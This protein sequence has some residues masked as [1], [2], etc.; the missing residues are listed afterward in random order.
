MALL[1][2][3]NIFGV[4]VTCVTVDNPRARQLNDYPGLNG[5][6]SLDQGLRGRFSDVQGIL[7]GEDLG[8][9]AALEGTVRSYYDGQVH[10]LTDSAGVD[11]SNVLLES[12]EPQ[13]KIRI[14][15]NDGACFRPYRCRFLH[16][17]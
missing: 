11:W 10:T 13:G 9:L 5:R 15:A 14:R 17:T 3:I 1:D 7:V 8:T 2:G 4:T 16:L 12:F 6:E